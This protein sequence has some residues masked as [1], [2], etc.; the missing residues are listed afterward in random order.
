MHNR[1]LIGLG[2]VATAACY[3]LV[4]RSQTNGIIGFYR[5]TLSA[6]MFA[7]WFAGFVVATISSPTCAICFWLLAK[8]SRHRWVIHLALVPLTYAVIRASAAV[9]LFATGEPDFDL[10]TGRAMLPAMVLLAI[11]STAYFIALLWQ[12]IAKPRLIVSVR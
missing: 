2:V 4:D 7:C 3:L 11:C 8:T 6:S 5:E 9:M 12:K 1:T 10:L